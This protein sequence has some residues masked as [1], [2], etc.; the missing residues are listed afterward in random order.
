MPPKANKKGATDAPMDEAMRAAR[1]GRVK[2]T[3]AM[4]FVGLPNVGKSSLTNLLS[5]AAHA[6]GANYVCIYHAF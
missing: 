3:L 2:N 4:G 6:E 1:F 5:G